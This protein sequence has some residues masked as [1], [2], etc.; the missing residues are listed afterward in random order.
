M[1]KIPDPV[2][3]RLSYLFELLNMLEKK[4]VVNIS[5]AEVGSFV[6]LS[7]HTI[8]K[9]INYLG[10]AGGRG[11]KYSIAELKKLLTDHLGFGEPKNCC[12]VGL[13]R[14]GESILDHMLKIKHEGLKIVA[15]FDSNINRLETIK[16][17]IDLFPAYRI[18]EIIS[19]MNIELALITVPPQNAQEAADRCCD[20]GVKGILNL[21]SAVI[22][23]KCNDCFVRSVDFFSELRILTAL[24][25]TNNKNS[26]QT[27]QKGEK[28]YGACL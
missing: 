8:R 20:G 5:S 26:P 23:P 6:G 11:K 22:R 28:E 27:I 16:T 19:R 9:D 17:T 24:I 25:F 1:N 3:Y 13:G 2:I 14:V 10:I 4:G 15:G 12:I 21:T 7:S 18:E